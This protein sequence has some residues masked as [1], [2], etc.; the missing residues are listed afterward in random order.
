M[1]ITSHFCRGSLPT[2]F[3]FS[4]PG[5]EE[6]S[7]GKPVAG[8]TGCNLQSA[9]VHLRSELPSLFPSLER[10]DYRITNAFHEPIAVSLGHRA[11]EASDA[12]I[13][14]DANTLRVLQELDGCTL[15]ILCGKKA[16]LLAKA[17]R[18]SG[19]KV[20]GVPHLGNK[21]LNLCYKIPTAL[22]L[23][24]PAAR[25]EYRVRMWAGALVAA[26]AE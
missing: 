14:D 22:D 21:A 25:R 18:E 15:V 8:E 24:S 26:T 20:I 13:T 10:Y 23:P 7:M 2:A 17:I 6:L 11:S 12:Q 16:Q 9:L 19:K 1:K 4:T 3:V 5:E